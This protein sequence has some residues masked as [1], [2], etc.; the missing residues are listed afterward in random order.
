MKIQ[1]RKI[2][3]AEGIMAGVF[4]GTAAIFIRFLN[5]LH[6]F[7]I[8]FWRLTIACVALVLIML[9]FKKTFQFNLV[10]ENWKLLLFLGF[11]LGLHFIFFVSAV[12][13]TT[14]LNATVLVNTT[15]I[16]STLISKVF[17]K[18]KPSRLTIVG[19]VISFIGICVVGYTES[20]MVN[21]NLSLVS[22]SSN[23]RGDI[24]AILAALVEAFYLNYGRKTRGQIGILPVMLS[25][26]FS[27]ALTVGI[28][29]VLLTPNVLTFPSEAR[30]FMPILGLGLLP[31][32]VAH[33]F[34]FS[35]LSGLKPFETAT[36]ALL[37]PLGATALGILVFLEM[38]SPIFTFGASLILLGIFFVLKEKNRSV[39]ETNKKE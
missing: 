13:D 29:N 5:D 37:E 22:F 38:P 32:A 21:Q 33:T 1:T 7:S 18:L 4:F 26:Y 39:Y 3:L 19:I 17:F 2:A 11:L 23:L 25:V 35:S 24:E 14:I 34:Y 36:M 10:K 20:V 16:F 9:A 6:A 27:A 8:A 12:K 28:L 30:F 15:P 31:T